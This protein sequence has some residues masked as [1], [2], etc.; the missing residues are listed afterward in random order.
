[1]RGLYAKLLKRTLSRDAS[2]REVL[3]LGFRESKKFN[4]GS[5]RASRLAN[6]ISNIAVCKVLSEV[7]KQRKLS[8]GELLKTVRQVNDLRLSVENLDSV[9]R[10]HHLSLSSMKKVTTTT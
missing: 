7:L 4:V 5:M 3:V 10:Q 1:M 2:L 6:A 8:A 9:S